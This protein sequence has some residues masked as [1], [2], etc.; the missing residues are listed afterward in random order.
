MIFY[1]FDAGG[2]EFMFFGFVVRQA[3]I[4]CFWFLHVV[5]YR[6]SNSSCLDFLE[7]VQVLLRAVS[8]SRNSTGIA[9]RR[10]CVPKMYRYSV[11]SLQ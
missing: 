4:L 6:A 3:P 7:A 1:T 11:G 2:V 9:S 10:F 8:V 5:S